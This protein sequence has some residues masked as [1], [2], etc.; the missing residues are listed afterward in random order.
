MPITTGQGNPDWTRDETIL[1]LELLMRSEMHPPGKSSAEVGAL[2][3]LLRAM[4]FH[5]AHS[6][7][8]NFRN[9]DGVYLKL[10]NLRACG[11]RSQISSSIM[12]RAV[13]D[14]FY[15]KPDRLRAAAERVRAAVEYL[16]SETDDEHSD[17][18][19]EEGGVQMR[20]HRRRE[21]SPKLRGRLLAGTRAKHGCLVCAACGFKSKSEYALGDVQF[22]AHHLALL[23]ITGPRT[24]RIGD[25][26]LLCANCHRLV[27]AAMR[28]TKGD[29]SIP[30]LA[31]LALA[32]R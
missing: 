2:S 4:P 8:E 7:K 18:A 32:A 1:A 14:E 16:A 25:L 9:V 15:Q 27:H 24:T 19:E 23:S 5:P 17:D 3:E 26:A 13:W 22:E 30:E 11:V 29:V 10:Q 20:A 6:R 21:R 31:A 12:D 28:Q